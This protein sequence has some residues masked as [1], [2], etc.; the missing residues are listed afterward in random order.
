MS[1]G[2]IVTFNDPRRFGFMKLVPRA[3]L[4]EEPLLRALGPEPLGNAFDAAMLARACAG[5]KTQP[6]GRAARPARRR[7]ARQ[8]L[9]LRGAAPRAAVAQAQR[10]DDRRPRRARR[11]SAPSALVDAIKAVLNDA[12]K[13]GGSS[14]RDHRRTDGE[15]GD[16]Q[17]N[18]RV[19]DR[20]GKPCPT[21]RLQRHDPA[22]RADRPLDVLL[23]GLPE[24]SP[25]HSP[26]NS[27][28]CRDFYE[29]GVRFNQHHT[30]PQSSN[31]S[32]RY[33]QGGLRDRRVCAATIRRQRTGRRAEGT[34]TMGYDD[35]KRHAS[36]LAITRGLSRMLI[37]PA[38][39][40]AA[41][42]GGS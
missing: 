42:I 22:H 10:L 40:Q 31:R 7:R 25:S 24:V 34:R 23:P 26:R 17:H 35:L 21:P 28:S 38:S 33:A 8:H 29:M 30:D 20:E 1:S 36:L 4:D 2:A 14:L 11:T 27:M 6:E 37:S 39:G 19:Y 9:C 5:K 41:A 32:H 15:L 18:F 3:T 12:I 13:A 16:F